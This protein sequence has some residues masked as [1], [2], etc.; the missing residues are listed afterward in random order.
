MDALTWQ[1]LPST[2]LE[3]ESDLLALQLSQQPHKRIGLDADVISLKCP[4]VVPAQQGSEG[5]LHSWKSEVQPATNREPHDP[6]SNQL[7][8]EAEPAWQLPA[9]NPK[10][11]GHAE[12]EGQ[13]HTLP[14]EKV[15]AGRRPS[16]G[17]IILDV[18]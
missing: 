3:V 9:S 8:T 15:E 12:L 16:E 4:C 13:L 5:S 17:A 11:I 14:T 10:G 6:L 1:T 2:T 7:R 18:S